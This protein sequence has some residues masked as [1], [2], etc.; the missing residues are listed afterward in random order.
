MLEAHCES[1]SGYGIQESRG[2][3]S[4][5]AS[6]V[7]GSLPERWCLNKN[8][9]GEGVNPVGVWRDVLGAGLAKHRWSS[10]RGTRLSTA[11]MG[12]WKETYKA[13]MFRA[14]H[15]G[16]YTWGE[17]MFPQLLHL[18]TLSLSF[19]CSTILV[20]QFLKVKSLPMSGSFFLEFSCLLVWLMFSVTSPRKPLLSPPYLGWFPCG[21]QPQAPVHFLL[22][23]SFI[24][25]LLNK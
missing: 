20:F 22:S 24:Y 15:L 13:V 3:A 25:F 7:A 9:G 2:W 5:S 11:S 4:C 1:I 19:L 10:L 17:E 18:L 23:S 6:K 14:N 12:Q 16:L 21:T 8:K